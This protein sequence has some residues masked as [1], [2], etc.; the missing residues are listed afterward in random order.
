MKDKIRL[1]LEKLIDPS[2]KM[3]LKQSEGIKHIGYDE[4]HDLVTLIIAIGKKSDQA[5]R[6]LRMDVTKLI[7]QTL[8]HKGLKLEIEE[9]KKIE[10]ITKGKC[11]FIGI[12]S[13]KG[14]VGKSTVV[15]NIANRLMKKG[16]KVG[17]IDADIY[18]SSIPKLLNVPHEFPHYDENQKIA[19]I[20]YQTMQVISTEFFTNPKEPVIW[21]GGMLH[22]MLE[23]FFYDVAWDKELEYMLIDLPPGTGDVM[24]DVKSYIPQAKMI[25]V[26]T[27]HLSAS[28]VAIKAGFA[29]LKLDHQI[30]GVI[31][32]MSYYKNPI[33]GQREN[34]FG[35]GGGLEV[36]K[37]LG[38]ELL[39]QIPIDQPKKHPAIF[40][41]D[42]D[43]GKLYDDI[44]D[45]IIFNEVDYD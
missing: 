20:T 35:E 10:S 28:H 3:S 9:N 26:T 7:K 15:V 17:I 14:G 19:P 27:P 16:H 31:E 37:L 42:E 6:S 8:G 21:R 24:L 1:E 41:I 25:I 39:A 44:A 32:N 18:G 2:L 40:D 4:E 22:S 5:E 38:A 11:T 13:G 29:A 23:H 36:S 12:T 45:L 43:N 30:L 34:I 33:N